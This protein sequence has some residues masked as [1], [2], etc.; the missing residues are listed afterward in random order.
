VAWILEAQSMITE[1]LTNSDYLTP[2]AILVLCGFGLPVPEEV[3]LLGAGFLLFQGRVEVVPIIVVCFVATLIGDSIPFWVG[4]RFGR[5]ALRNRI[6]RRAV[7]PERMRGIMR[8]FERQ[9]VRAVFVCRFIPG[10]RLPAWFTAGT[11]GMPYARFIAVDALGAAILTPLFILV[12]RASGEKVAELERTVENFHQIAAFVALALTATFVGHLLITK[13]WPTAA[14]N[15]GTT[16]EP[17]PNAGR[18]AGDRESEPS[19]DPAP[20]IFEPAAG[21]GGTAAGSEDP[22]T[23]SGGP[24][25][26][27]DGTEREVLDGDRP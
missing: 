14:R 4:R 11:L 6:V 22:V 3:T 10:L 19:S 7:H 16:A 2:F 13:R 12:G 5:Q 23:A 8:R 9:G 27:P 1:L 26:D 15:G 24:K 20:P 25:A 18:R 17:T 21:S